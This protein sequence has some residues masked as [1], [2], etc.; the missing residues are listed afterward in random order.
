MN[1]IILSIIL[2][3]VLIILFL[4]SPFNNLFRFLNRD[5]LEDYDELIIKID[6]IEVNT[7][8]NPINHFDDYLILIN[9]VVNFFEAELESENEQYI[10]TLEEQEITLIKRDYESIKETKII[11]NTI[12][13]KEDNLFISLDFLAK[14]LN[15]NVYINI[16]EGVKTIGLETVNELLVPYTEAL[17]IFAE[18]KTATVT[19][20]ETGITYEVKRVIG[21]YTYL[22]DV[23]PLTAADTEKL[24]EAAGGNWTFKRRAVIVTIDGIDI[25]ASIAP[26]P[27]SGRDDAPFGVIVDNRSGG[28]RR[29][30]NL[31][32]IRDNNMVGV[33]DIFFYNS[34]IPGV[35]KIDERHQLMIL[36]A[37]SSQR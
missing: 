8:I 18:G 5:V 34:L 25:A 14:R 30:I 28:T 2:I 13:E 29:G 26:Y 20:V 35:N 22:A 31:N 19:D 36:K 21:G 17:K 12:I 11:N 10:L 16:R 23:E 1:K 6:N 32:S 33:V 15:Y 3:M 7:E 4:L 9:A 27:H 37:A 24:L